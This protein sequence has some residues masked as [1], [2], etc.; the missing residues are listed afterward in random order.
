MILCSFTFLSLLGNKLQTSRIYCSERL[1][2]G[3][4]T[5]KGMCMI[6]IWSFFSIY[7]I[8]P[9]I[10]HTHILSTFYRGLLHSLLLYPWHVI[11]IP[12]YNVHPYCSLKIWAKLYMAKYGSF[13]LFIFSVFFKC[14]MQQS[15]L[16]TFLPETQQLEGPLCFCKEKSLCLITMFKSLQV[17]F[18]G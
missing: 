9:C 18:P 16:R 2:I 5:K 6:E 4:Y 13:C 12:V 7:R 15:V 17:H 10:M 11:I 8:L 1:V 14:Y 3:T